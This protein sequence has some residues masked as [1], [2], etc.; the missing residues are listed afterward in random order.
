MSLRRTVAAAFR[1]RGT[2]RLAESEFVVAVS[3]D[4]G[5][6]SPDQAERLLDVAGGEGLVRYEGDEVVPTF[7]LDEVH[8]PDGF[9]PEESVLRER[10][11]FE[12]V[13]ETLTD[14]GHGKQEAVAS[15]NRL[16]DD[17]GVTVAAA[18]VV[19]A[20]QE[21]VDVEDAAARARLELRGDE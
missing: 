10:S 3:L 1:E 20:R 14:A 9:E 13:L 5:W 2:D 18:A 12:R 7:S 17:L 8:V 11:A 6:F 21:G 19:Y 4:R 15:I 16:Q